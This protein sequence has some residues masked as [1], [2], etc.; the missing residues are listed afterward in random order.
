MIKD[1]TMT[2]SKIAVN[3]L[4]NQNEQVKVVAAV[5]IDPVT[6]LPSDGGGSTGSN[7]DFELLLIQDS[8]GATGIRREV[9]NNGTIT[10]NYETLDGGSWTPTPPTSLVSAALPPNAATA[11][12]QA[13]LLTVVQNLLIAA[14]MPT[15]SAVT[16]L[17]VATS[18]SAGATATVFG[19]QACTGLD[20]VNS[21]NVDIEYQRGGA[22]QFMTISA[23][24]SR[25]VTGITNANQIGV[26]RVDQV[27]TAVTIKAEAF[28]V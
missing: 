26:R 13:T 14:K 5:L 2:T 15:Y 6:G 28:A 1:Y 3:V 21:S 18:A 19:A 20:I 23:G 16:I 4:N 9:N 8:T 10:V 17:S 27:A 22:G 11:S 24:T 12:A 25:L 7:I